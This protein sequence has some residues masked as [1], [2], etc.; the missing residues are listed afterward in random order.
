MT[1]LF[2]NRYRIQSARLP[3]WDYAANGMYFITICT[4]NKE[5]FFGSL[6]N[7]LVELNQVGLLVN[8]FW[9]NIPNH[10]PSANLD[11][12][13]VMPNHL[14]GIIYISSGITDLQPKQKQTISSI[15]GSFKSACTKTINEQ[16]PDIPFGWQA[17]FHDHII[18]NKQ[19]LDQIRDY[20]NN[21]PRQWH[22]DKENLSP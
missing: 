7:D 22:L 13:V 8:A 15:I 18:R 5:K 4:K 16:Y 17:R 3:D 21:N 19:S 14:H 9:Q 10:F 20:I 11:T 12:Y 1:D 2:N 6:E